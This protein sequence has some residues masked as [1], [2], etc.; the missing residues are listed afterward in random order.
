MLYLVLPSGNMLWSDLPPSVRIA[1][2]RNHETRVD[3]FEWQQS[4]F[5]ADD[6]TI[7]LALRYGVPSVSGIV[8]DGLTITDHHHARDIVRAGLDAQSSTKAVDD[9]PLMNHIFPNWKKRGEEL[10][11]AITD[12]IMDTV[13]AARE[14]V[15]LNIITKE[16]NPALVEHWGNLSGY[17]PDPL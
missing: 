9:D 17:L 7:R 13:T 3:E 14:R 11:A 8:I 16:P 1:D 4:E 6:T 2:R 12:S 10:S 5:R 15:E